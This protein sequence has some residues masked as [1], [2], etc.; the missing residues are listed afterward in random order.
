MYQ[1]LLLVSKKSKNPPKKIHN[2]LD[3]DEEIEERK[4]L[5]FSMISSGNLGSSFRTYFPLDLNQEKLHDAE[6]LEK[7]L[8]SKKEGGHLTAGPLRN[9]NIKRFAYGMETKESSCYSGKSTLIQQ[10]LDAVEKLSP[11]NFSRMRIAINEQ[12]SEDY[13]IKCFEDHRPKMKKVLGVHFDVCAHADFR[14]F[15]AILTDLILG[16]VIMSKKG[17]GFSFLGIELHL[18]FELGLASDEDKFEY[19][20]FQ[21]P[22]NVL[23]SLPIIKHFGE[24]LKLAQAVLLVITPDAR[25]LARYILSYNNA[26]NDMSQLPPADPD[27]NNVRRILVQFFNDVVDMRLGADHLW[28][29]ITFRRP[30]RVHQQRGFI[31][32]I[33]TRLQ[34]FADWKEAVKKQEDMIAA[35]VAQIRIKTKN[36]HYAEEAKFKVSDLQAMLPTMFRAFTDECSYLC[37]DKLDIS[38]SSNRNIHLPLFTNRFS[39]ILSMNEFL[40]IFIH[41]P[42]LFINFYC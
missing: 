16:G 33:S 35:E 8:C 19:K 31:Q 42:I 2:P 13:V 20:E 21:D 37:Q 39:M 4:L 41:F 22:Q 15:N 5:N 18:F 28:K 1:F 24:D 38:I 26:K 3:G 40:Y 17:K 29:K 9:N 32:L 12:L 6:S 7:S 30:N 34:F 27:D 36:P 25:M 11:S 14:L 23:F 10:Q